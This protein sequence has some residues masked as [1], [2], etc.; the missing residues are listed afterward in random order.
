MELPKRLANEDLQLTTH[1]C[2]VEVF[3]RVTGFF[4]PVQEW[5]DGKAEEFKDRS[6]YNLGGEH[7]KTGTDNGDND[8]TS[9]S[10]D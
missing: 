7:G 8:S 1:K 5:N 2:D 3:S 9:S 4:R 6:K 10:N